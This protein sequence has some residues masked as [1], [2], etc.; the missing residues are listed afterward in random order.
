M[1]CHPGLAR[2][3]TKLVQR[4]ATW[5]GRPLVRVAPLRVGH[6]GCAKCAPLQ[7]SQG[8]SS[9]AGKLIWPNWNRLNPCQARAER[10]GRYTGVRV[11]AC[12]YPVVH[13]EQLTDL[14]PCTCI[15]SLVPRLPSRSS[16][17][18]VAPQM[19]LNC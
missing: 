16:F 18:S 15:S 2:R 10:F 7:A 11:R 5:D 1:L 4:G 12:A 9:A 19:Q 3:A 13:V 14:L 6:V 8:G 17:A